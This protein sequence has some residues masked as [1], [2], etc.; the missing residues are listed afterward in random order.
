MY[1]QTS[2][3]NP[4]PK[5]LLSTSSPR[6]LVP[7]PFPQPFIPVSLAC[8]RALSHHPAPN[9]YLT[10]IH[11]HT[12]THTRQAIKYSSS[13]G[14]G[15]V[16]IW[17]ETRA[18]SLNVHFIPFQSLRKTIVTDRRADFWA[19]LASC[20]HACGYLSLVCKH[21]WMCAYVHMYACTYVC[22]Y[23]YVCMYVHAGSRIPVPTKAIKER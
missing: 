12:H 23:L 13:Q 15:M 1:C 16:G 3:S 7:T 4:K 10:Y 20:R 5:P 19:C 22:V 2:W 17:S 9:C 14:E 18:S 6:G 11:T 8:A 21:V